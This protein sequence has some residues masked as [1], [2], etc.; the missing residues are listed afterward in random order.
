MA[1][2]AR[3]VMADSNA[4][5]DLYNGK[6]TQ[7]TLSLER[8]LREERVR[9]HS[10]VIKEF[11]LGRKNNRLDEHIRY[12]RL[13]PRVDDLSINEFLAVVDDFDLR[14]S[15]K[16]RDTFLFAA[17]IQHRVLVLTSDRT[18]QRKCERVGLCYF[19]QE[20]ISHEAALQ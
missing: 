7:A 14:G 11:A 3:P 5:F 16:S 2:D 13:L 17:A 8:L 1:A 18:F 4:W 12:L 9:V 15:G 19:C 20:G 6:R 10:D